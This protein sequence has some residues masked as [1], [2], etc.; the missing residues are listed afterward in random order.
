MTVLEAGR[1]DRDGPLSSVECLDLEI[2][3]CLVMAPLKSMESEG[4]VPWQPH[5]CVGENANDSDGDAATV[6][7]DGDV[8]DG[9]G[10]LSDLSDLN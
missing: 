7:Y 1:S 9:D 3:Q 10:T 4:A 8:S 6:P 5:R 2:G